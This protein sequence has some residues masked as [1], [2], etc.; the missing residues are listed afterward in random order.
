[1][2]YKLRR[3]TPRRYVLTAQEAHRVL[4]FFFGKGNV[5]L[6]VAGLTWDDLEF[7]QA[8]LVEGIEATARLSLAMK[9][10]EIFISDGNIKSILKKLIRMGFKGWFKDA[11]GDDLKDPKIAKTVRNRIGGGCKVAWQNRLEAGDSIWGQL[12]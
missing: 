7:A 2:S 4:T 1:M 5:R 6:P 11:K 3:P 9:I 8:M 10:I 12:Y